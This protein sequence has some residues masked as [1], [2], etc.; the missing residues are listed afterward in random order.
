MQRLALLALTCGTALATMPVPVEGQLD[1]LR[2]AGRRAVESVQNAA[3]ERLEEK[4]AGAVTCRVDDTACADDARSE[5]ERP[6]FV[7]EEGNVITDANGDP[8]TDPEDARAAMS[9]P[10]SEVWRNYDFVPGQTVLYALDLASEPIG[11]WPASQMVFGRG[12]GQV[13]EYN[14]ARAVEFTERSEFRVALPDS[15]PDD[16]TIELGFKAG[17]VNLPLRLFVDPP[18]DVTPGGNRSDR[19]Y[20]Q[21]SSRPGVYRRGNDVSATPGLTQISTEVVPFALQVDGDA[22]QG[23]P[24]SDYTILYAGTERVAQLPNASFKRGD[25][26][27]IH[28]RANARFPAYLTSLVVAVHGDPLYEALSTG[29]R[30]FSTRGI[31]FDFDSDR[32]RGESTPTLDELFTTLDTHPELNVVIEGHTD[33]SGDDDY[34]RELSNRRARAVVDHLVARGIAPDRLDAVGIGEAQPVADNATEAG[35]RQNRRV[36]IRAVEAG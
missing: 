25:E 22:E 12:N 24:P 4:I 21:L 16:F 35:R 13:V 31:L 30:E 17:T 32:L 9:E 20:V 34:N 28:I 11:R 18:E 33:A 36:V 3:T 15:L 26:L 19:D 27:E 2:R 7:D 5:G 8:I 29:D 23:D 14:G 6:V 1:R 10:G